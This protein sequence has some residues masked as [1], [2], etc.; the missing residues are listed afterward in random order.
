MK[1]LIISYF[2][3]P[4]N[5]TASQRAKG[6]ATYLK[7][8]DI[9][10][11]VVTR[12]WDTPI[13]TPEDVLR[14]TKDEDL[15][16]NDDGYDVYYMPYKPGLRDRLFVKWQ[17]SRL[18]G[19]SKL[20]TFWNLIWENYSIGVI[21][22]QNMYY[23]SLEILREHDV[24]AFVISANPFDQFHFGYELH[25]KTG[26]PWIA[27]YRDDWS[28]TELERPGGFLNRIVQNLQAK[29]EKKWVKTASCITSVSYHYTR[30][31]SQFVGV[32]G[33]T[34]LNGYELPELSPV[35]PNKSS[36]TITYNGSLYASQNI[37]P[38]LEAIKKCM[39]KF[40]GK[41]DLR[42]KFPGLAFDET[43]AIRISNAM[44]GY[45]DRLE[46][47]GRIPRSEVLEIQQK[48]D[49]VIMVAHYGIKGIPSSKLY[50][51]IGL[52]KPVLLFP[53]DGDILENTLTHTGLGV[54]CKEQN[55]IYPRL[56]ELIEQKCDKGQVQLDHNGSVIPEYSRKHQVKELAKLL[57]SITDG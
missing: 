13:E 51:Y 18:Q 22:H 5:L 28:T 54:I 8:H 26:I 32:E 40:A 50:E 45:E 49:L 9:E 6:W 23:R 14:V 36:F 4:Y 48:S 53:S 15:H 52:E 33:K 46:I 31:I 17:N 47:T 41:I 56:T 37:E 27:D 19:L 39:D 2:S 25:R 21:P 16:K 24:D 1:V 30:K 7:D 38:I 44:Q 29:S 11:I 43:Q 3:P 12:R 55:E 57:R 34:L 42:L 10:P 20:V 35:Q